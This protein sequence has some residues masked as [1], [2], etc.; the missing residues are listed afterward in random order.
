[1]PLPDND[2]GYAPDARADEDVW[3]TQVARAVTSE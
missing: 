2:G 1:V 3:P